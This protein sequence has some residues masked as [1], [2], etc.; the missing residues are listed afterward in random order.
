ERW[1]AGISS[2][3]SASAAWHTAAWAV[4]G[5]GYVGG[6]VFV[7]SVLGAGATDVILVLVAGSRLSAYIGATVGEIGFL[8]GIWMDGSKRLA[9]LEDY[10][11]SLTASADKEVP[12]RLTRG[13]RL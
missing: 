4:F 3:R 13:V 11:A 5:A 7:S 12:A 6:I 2:A 1:Y 9:W 8:R 10:A